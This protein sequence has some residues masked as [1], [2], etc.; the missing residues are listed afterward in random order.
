M[1]ILRMKPLAQQLLFKNK[2]PPQP[3]PSHCPQLFLQHI[4]M[5]AR[6]RQISRITGK[7]QSSLKAA[8]SQQ[9]GRAAVPI[10]AKNVMRKIQI[11]HLA[12]GLKKPI[13][14]RMPQAKS[15]LLKKP[16]RNKRK[17]KQTKQPSSSSSK[18]KIQSQTL[19]LPLQHSSL[20]KFELRLEKID[21]KLQPVLSGKSE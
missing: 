18:K 3:L 8:Q 7:H 12:N 14:L 20:L 11:L 9:L 5:S 21:E 2:Q 4:Q 15:A 1:G 16:T 17:Q 6:S 10:T 13:N 19:L